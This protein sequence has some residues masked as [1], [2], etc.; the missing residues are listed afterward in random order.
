MENLHEILGG[1]GL[2]AGA[3]LIVFI[4]AKYNYLIQKAK[5]E[6]GLVDT[7]ATKKLKYLD[8]GC[9]LLGLGI[10]LAISSVFTTMNLLEDTADLLIWGTILVFSS[11]GLVTAHYI[12][13][14]LE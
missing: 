14:R 6:R 12:R 9:I 5:I 4:I 11:A 8:I 10:G 2:I 7:E 3:V 1:I 13:K